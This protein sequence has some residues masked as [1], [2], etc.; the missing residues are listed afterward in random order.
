M[1]LKEALLVY[2]VDAAS[3]LYSL[4]ADRIVPARRAPVDFLPCVT[5]FRVSRTDSYVLEGK[6][7]G[8]PEERIQFD[9]W[10]R[11]VEEVEAVADALR[12][13][14][15]GPLRGY[16]GAVFIQSCR[17]EESGRD[18]YEPPDHADDAAVFQVSLDALIAYEEEV[19]TF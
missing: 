6:S 14:L 15:N 3:D 13:R 17:F 11:T 8:L 1:T 10:G 18:N 7:G 5:F 16:W 4:V 2:L 9:C 12:S 19:P